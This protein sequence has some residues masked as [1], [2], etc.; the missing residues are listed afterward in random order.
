LILDRADA[1]IGVLID[2]LV[3]RGTNEPYRMF[4]S[5]AEYRLQLRADNAD[6][7]L[8]DKG[9][10]I[11]CVGTDRARSWRDKKSAIERARMLARNL[12]ASSDRLRGAGLAVNDNGLARTAFELFARSD[13]SREVIIALWPELSMVRQ[14][15]YQQIV[16]EARYAG[17]M[18]RQTLDIAAFRQDEALILPEGLDYDSMTSLSNEAR[19][20]LN[21]IRPHTLGAAA[22]ISGI[23]PAAIFSLLRYVKR[24]F[25]LAQG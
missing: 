14:D 3:M 1:Y 6:D 15:V 10:K 25:P 20:K 11:G 21:R 5:R 2:D 8:T 19:E 7:R 23:T 4:T 9:I 17:Y 18:E 12:C 22:R 13:V 24:A 16:I